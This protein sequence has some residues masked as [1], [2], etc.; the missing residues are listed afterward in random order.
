MESGEV[1]VVY[2]LLVPT[3]MQHYHEK[4]VKIN[5][6]EPKTIH[7]KRKENLVRTHTTHTK[8]NHKHPMMI[9]EERRTAHTCTVLTHTHTY[10][11][12]EHI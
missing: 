2:L 5:K 3:Y 7:K 1:Y 6:N 9:F 8:H 4:I 10:T 12:F 11:C